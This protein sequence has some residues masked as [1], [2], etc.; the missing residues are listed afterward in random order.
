MK[1]IRMVCFV[2]VIAGA[3]LLGGC[4]RVRVE[5]GLTAEEQWALANRHFETENYL[6]AIDVLAIF[7]L[8]YS[9]ST[10][11]DSA[12][13]LLGECHFALNEYILAESEYGRLVQN[14]PQSPLVD[15]ARLKIIL[16]NVYLSPNYSLDQRFT[17]KTLTTVQNFREDYAQT[18]MALHLTR[19]PTTWEVL[20]GIFSL[21]T[22]KPARSNVK[23][24]PLFNTEVVYPN[25]SS[26]FG[27]WLLRVLTIGL[28]HPPLAPLS[29]P[30]SVEVSGDWIVNRALEDTR[31]RLAKKD[32]KAGELYYQQEKYPSAII[33]FDRVLE[34]YA[35]TP[36]AA[37][38]LKLKGNSYFEMKK[39]TE[40]ANA[41][42]I[43]LREFGEDQQRE[44]KTKLEE[45]QRRL[46]L[47]AAENPI[48][49]D[50]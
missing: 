35:D 20:G 13:Y 44:V 42:E 50:K 1:L 19:R 15:D 43:Y 23:S 21:G 14:F 24:V 17:E 39:Y 22:W 10:L 36:W 28:Y 31:A 46:Q 33:Y 5:E 30:P 26:S 47:P 34:L 41:Y 48:E 9:G 3:L 37:P 49:N 18:E 25:R 8:N 7:T 4:G 2:L 32:Y 16:C 11:I 29:I 6:D 45:S 12:Q 27:Q 40:A 38:A